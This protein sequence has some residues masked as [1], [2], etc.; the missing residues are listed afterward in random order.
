MWHPTWAHMVT[1]EPQNAQ[2]SVPLKR[3]KANSKE[4]E[5]QLWEQLPETRMN[6]Q[7]EGEPSLLNSCLQLRRALRPRQM[8]LLLKQWRAPSRL[9]CGLLLL[10]CTVKDVFLRE[11]R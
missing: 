4:S 5:D 8:C 1:A 3:R 11:L 7:E 9:K 2:H 6:D 10:I